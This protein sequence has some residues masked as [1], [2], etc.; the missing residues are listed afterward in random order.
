[1]A[2]A[3]QP[4]PEIIFALIGEVEISRLTLPAVRVLQGVH[5]QLQPGQLTVII[6]RSGSGKTTLL[7]ALTA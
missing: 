3:W 5:L 1:M 4:N 6:G 2:E 7:R